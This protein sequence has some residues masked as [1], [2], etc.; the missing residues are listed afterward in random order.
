MFRILVAGITLLGAPAMAG[1]FTPSDYS[2]NEEVVIKTLRIEKEGKYRHVVVVIGN[3]SAKP[4]NANF[5]C[6][7]IGEDGEAFDSTRGAANIVPPG[8]EV[9]SKSMTFQVDATGAACRI[10]LVNFQD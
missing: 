8:Q 4:F 9:I 1:E 6:T 3:R 7:L 10:E 2:P 5:G